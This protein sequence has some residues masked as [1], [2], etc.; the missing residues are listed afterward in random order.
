MGVGSIADGFEVTGG[1]R[2]NGR[3]VISGS[4]N[5][6]LPIMAAT[7]LADDVFHVDAMPQLRDIKAMGDIL[8]SL[9]ARITC[10]ESDWRGC[11]MTIDTRDLRGNHVPDP[12]MRQ[13]RS[14]IVLLGPL[15]VRFG[16]ARVS[17]PGGCVI[18]PRPIDFHLQGL[19]ALGIEIEEAHGELF[20]RVRRLRGAAVDLELPSVGTTAHLMLTAAAIPERTV[21]RNAAREPELVDLQ[22]LLRRMGAAVTG[23]GTPTITIEGRR[24]LRGAEHVVIPDRVEMGTFLAAAALTGGDVELV[25]VEPL[26]GQAVFSKLEQAGAVLAIRERSVRLTQRQALRAVNIRT[27]PYPGF[28]TDLQNVFL[29]LMLKAQGTSIITETI[30]SNRFRV[31]EALRRM[32]A[33][34]HVEDRVA[35]VHGGRPLT[36]AVV[37]I[38]E[39][40]RGGAALVLAGLVAEGT[41]TIW[42]ARFIDRGYHR[43]EQKLQSLGASIER[44]SDG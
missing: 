12:L 20:A 41:S 38:A 1:R 9:G 15:A 2:L 39:D 35:I 11:R 16:E 18:G 44:I 30:W 24:D 25:N 21:I 23:A 10:G 26:H 31:V 22:T 5:A 17:Y 14:S 33:D 40:L 34:I 28:P 29:T 36:A 13:M 27:Q 7:V 8:I 6:A 4:K 3:L 43:F 37:E 19:R 32:G 42:G